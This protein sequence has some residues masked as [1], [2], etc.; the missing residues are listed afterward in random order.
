MGQCQPILEYGGSKGAALI[1]FILNIKK[2]FFVSFISGVYLVHN[3][4][5]NVHII[6]S[7]RVMKKCQPK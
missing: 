7:N 5:V 2:D 6:D 4:K 3:K 1:S